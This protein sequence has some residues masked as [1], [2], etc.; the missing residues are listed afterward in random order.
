VKAP[1]Q[2]RLPAGH[3][4]ARPDDERDAPRATSTDVDTQQIR[5]K[6]VVNG[7]ISDYTNAT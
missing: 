4:L 2:D 3:R 5:R 1:E 6:P 7:L